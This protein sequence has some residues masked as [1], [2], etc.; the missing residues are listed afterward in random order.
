MGE[1]SIIKYSSLSNKLRLEAEYYQN[2]YL[3]V[4]EHL[5][6]LN[7]EKL[8]QYTKKITD[9]THYT[10]HYVEKGIKFYSATNVK[11]NY[12]DIS[13]K[14]KYISKKEH[15]SLY[16][17]CN[18]EPGDILIRKVGVGPRWSCVIPQTISEDFS[19]F[20]SVALLKIKN[21]LISPYYLSTFINCYHGQNQLLRVQ[22]GASQPD[23]HLEDIAELRVPRFGDKLEYQVE[24]LVIKGLEKQE[25]SRSLYAQAKELLEKELGLDQLVTDKRIYSV[26][27]FANISRSHRLDAQHFQSKFTDLIKHLSNFPCEKIKNIRIYNRRGIQPDYIEN[28]SIDV[29]NSQHIGKMHLKYDSLQ[30]TSERF[31]LKCPE[32]HIQENDLLIYTTGAYIGQTNV[33]LQNT[34]ALASN[35]VNILRIQPEIDPIYMTMVFQSVVGKFQTEM[36]SRGSAQV[37]LYPS[38]IDKFSVPIIPSETQKK[39]GDLVRN[40]L[41][42]ENES[43]QLL[44]QAK[45]RVVDL[46]EGVIEG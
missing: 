13:D 29:V 15:L 8:T 1:W 30:K 31:F 9:G 11:E 32:G 21:T 4:E 20:V 41:I 38:D 33:F 35:H 3:V 2:R 40:S 25:L 7:A 34:P 36:H 44:E 26:S 17:R 45:K 12:F 28:G 16:K 23:L 6:S 39:I 24:E 27:A 42:A 46:I 10:P 19:I 22:K 43:K 14:F 37:E 5:K 18:P